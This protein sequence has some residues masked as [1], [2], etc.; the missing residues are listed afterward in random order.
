MVCVSAA[1]PQVEFA[2]D[3][4][5]PPSNSSVAAVQRITTNSAASLNV[6]GCSF[7]T[8]TVEGSF[9]DIFGIDLSTRRYSLRTIVEELSAVV[10]DAYTWSNTLTVNTTGPL[11]QPYNRTFGLAYTGR[12]V[13]SAPKSTAV[14]TGK[15]RLQMATVSYLLG[16]DSSSSS[17]GSGGNGGDGDGSDNFA[18]R[19]QQATGPAAKVAAKPA[20]AGLEDKWPSRIEVS[21]LQ[22][23]GM[24]VW[25]VGRGPVLWGLVLWCFEGVLQEV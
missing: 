21:A 4:L 9:S 1:L 17:S 16:T 14:L 5:V 18:R 12:L 19:L 20:A 22:H 13:K 7:D 24:G 23:C 11:R 25:N 15:V 8:A 6:V 10:T 2:A 3:L